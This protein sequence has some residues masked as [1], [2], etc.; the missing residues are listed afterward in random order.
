M[1]NMYVPT[2]SIPSAGRHQIGS[3]THVC[4][5]S[6]SHA[7]C[8]PIPTTTFYHQGTSCSG[9]K[10]QKPGPPSIHKLATAISGGLRQAGQATTALGEGGQGSPKPRPVTLPVVGS[11]SRSQPR[12]VCPHARQ[13]VHA[14]RASRPMQTQFGTRPRRAEC[15]LPPCPPRRAVPDDGGHGNGSVRDATPSSAGA[16]VAP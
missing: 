5:K 12:K 14:H 2:L 4:T 1:E 10:R 16:S 9:G 13:S 15:S 8:L 11:A 7:L 3:C 6:L